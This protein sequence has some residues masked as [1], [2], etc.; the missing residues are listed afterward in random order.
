[1]FNDDNAH[2]GSSAIQV[3]LLYTKITKVNLSAFF[4]YSLLHEHVSPIVRTNVDLDLDLD[5]F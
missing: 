5:L 4:V 1:M 3:F 2:D